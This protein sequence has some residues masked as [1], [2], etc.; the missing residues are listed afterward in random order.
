MIVSVKSMEIVDAALNF[1]LAGRIKAFTFDNDADTEFD[2]LCANSR[3]GSSTAAERISVTV[4]RTILEVDA[5]DSILQTF[6][7]F[8]RIE[9]CNISP[10]SIEFEEYVAAFFEFLVNLIPFVGGIEFVEWL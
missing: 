1:F 7:R 5:A 8:N 2:C 9:F 10:V 4:L 3:N 6:H